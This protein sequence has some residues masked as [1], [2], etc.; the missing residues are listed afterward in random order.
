ME[1]SNPSRLITVNYRLI[2]YY[3]LV[4]FYI[5]VPAGIFVLFV[6]LFIYFVVVFAIIFRLVIHS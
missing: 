4:S 1:M 5:S 6:Y 3:F 2:Y